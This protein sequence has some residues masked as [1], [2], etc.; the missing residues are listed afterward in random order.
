MASLLSA[1]HAASRA[2]RRARGVKP[3]S[4]NMKERRNLPSPDEVV[5]LVPE[6][7]SDTED[8]DEEPTSSSSTCSGDSSCTSQNPSLPGSVDGS[9]SE[10]EGDAVSPE[11]SSSK[12]EA[13][14]PTKSRTAPID[15]D[16]FQIAKHLCEKAKSRKTLCEAFHAAD[17]CSDGY[18]TASDLA[19]VFQQ[20]K[21]PEGDAARFFETFGGDQRGLFWR[22]AVAIIH[23]L[24]R[25]EA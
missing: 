12:L 10:C 19:A 22:E 6:H 13:K 8:E 2:C 7:A 14:I 5:R 21:M 23:P 20:L 17:E 11:E 1:A 18:L 16:G 15:R 24:F 25:P 4:N 3:V 9:D